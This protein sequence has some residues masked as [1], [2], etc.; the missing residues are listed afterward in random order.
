MN[1]SSVIVPGQASV[2]NRDPHPL[3]SALNLAHCA[4][5]VK[6]NCVTLGTFQRAL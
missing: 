2:W 1:Y 3:F 6:G 4:H 5:P